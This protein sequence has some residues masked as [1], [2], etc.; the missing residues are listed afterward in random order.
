VPSTTT[1]SPVRRLLAAAVLALLGV[2]LATPAAPA[3]AH[4]VLTSA[5]PA[6]GEEL[7]SAPGEVRLTFNEPVTTSTESLRVFDADATRIDDGLVADGGDGQVAAALP[8]DLPDGAYVAVYRVTSADSHPIGGVLTFTVGDAEQLDQAAIEAI[9]GPGEGALGTVGSILRGLGYVGTL[10]AAGAVAFAAVVAR[11]PADRR[12]AERLG[13][14]AAVAGAV[15]V[16]LHLPVQAAAVSGY[17]LLEVLTDGGALGAVLTSGFGWS[18]L[19]RMIALLALAAPWFVAARGTGTAGAAPRGTSRP[20]LWLGAAAVLALG[21]YLLDGHQRTVE[22]TWLLATGDAVHLAAGAAWFGG[23]VLLLATL[24]TTRLEDDPV[25]GAT[26]VSRFSRLAAW[27]VL[28]LTVAGTAMAFPLVR[29]FDALTSTAYGWTLLAKVALAAVVVAIAA[30]NRRTLVPAVVARA[31]PAGGASLDEADVATAD[32]PPAGE[33]AWTRLTRTVQLE[34][35]LLVAVLGLTGFLVTTQP[36]AEAAGLTGPASVDTALTDD[37]TL[38]VTVDPAE[39]GLNAIHVYAFDDTGQ[40]TDE[41]DTVRLEF[42]QVEDDIGPIPVEPFVAGP[43]HWTATIDDLRFAG[44]WEVRVVGG[45]G[46]FD[47][48]EVTVPFTVR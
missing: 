5:T 30:Y 12:R 48:V 18:W 1:A 36:A 27:S 34:A 26:V 9:A 28:A 6:D 10:L 47:E 19:V 42:T 15:V 21:S 38:N 39:V 33:E 44:D 25:G 7:D 14:P 8:S 3:H 17:G 32:G 16:A 4:A 41:I 13:R 31:V 43:G 45:I 20:L 35:V 46:R 37:V 11:G 24:R 2:L 29:G 40:L 23:L 22:P